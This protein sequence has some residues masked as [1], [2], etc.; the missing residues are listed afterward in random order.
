MPAIYAIGET[1]YD[2]IFKNGIPVA[3]KAGGSMLNTAVSLGRLGL[4][5]SFISDMGDDRLADE[6]ISFLRNNGIMTGNIVK[7]PGYKSALAIA[8]LDENNNAEYTFYRDYPDERL[9]EVSIN[10][11]EN[12]ILLFG[13][14]FALTCEVRKPL[15]KIVTAARNAG[16]IVIYDPNFRKAH[17]HELENLRP[18]I[19]E[20]I[21]FADI[22][23]GSDEDFRY[24]YNARSAQESYEKI[25][26]DGCKNL[27]VT[28]NKE[29]VYAL[30]EGLS[31][32][33]DVPEIQVVSSIGAGD[34]FNAGVIWSIVQDNIRKKDL[35]AMTERTW[36]HLAENGI[37][38]ASEVCRSYE[39]YISPEFAMK[40]TAEI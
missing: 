31:L 37:D 7:Y 32:Y 19:R 22:V 3:A 25:L 21:S 12:D 33:Y 2:I 40:R 27:I 34:N 14:F 28:A 26:S 38:F 10:F 6:I 39:N 20:N 35:Q 24:V 9:N 29:G 5:V 1:V 30:S 15:L 18:Y 8:F 36:N 17:L 11:Q 13:S 4:D 23:R 16:S